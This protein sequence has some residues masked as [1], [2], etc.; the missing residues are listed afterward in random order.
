[1]EKSVLAGLKEIPSNSPEGHSFCGDIDMRITRS[2]TWYYHGS[3]IRRKQLVKLF[4]SVLIRD[5]EGDFWLETPA[6]KCRIQVEDAPFVALSIDV[7]GEGR[8]QTVKFITNVEEQ[9]IATPENPI[10]VDINPET[11]EPSPYILVRDGLHALI[12]RAVFYELVE[13]GVEEESPE[14]KFLGVWSGGVFFKLGAV[15]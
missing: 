7:V 12:S 13:L 14:G 15:S 2:G 4:S 9:V 3:P 5:E 8:E 10:W 1:M 11:L 6:E